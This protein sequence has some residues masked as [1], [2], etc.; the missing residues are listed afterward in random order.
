MDITDNARTYLA[1]GAISARWLIWIKA[2]N[3][4]TGAI[5]SV[6]ITTHEDDLTVTI[7]SETRTYAGAGPIVGIPEITFESGTVI[8][9]QR[10]TLSIIDANVINLIRAYDATLAPVEMRLVFF[11]PITGIFVA[12]QPLESRF[13][14][15]YRGNIDT[16]NIQI[17]ESASC[18]VV[19]VSQNR[20]GTKTLALKKSDAA[21]KLRNPNDNGRKYAS[22]AGTI[23]V[24]W[25]QKSETGFRMGSRG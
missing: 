18:E 5:E 22:I 25:G 9:N 17:G 10:L 13:P 6:G 24:A 4:E 1:K 8:Q 19:V 2:K 12:G 15:A 23:E 14:I 20:A 16:I 3:R 21:Q 7:G 11:D